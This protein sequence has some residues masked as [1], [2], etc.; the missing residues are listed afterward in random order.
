MH[1]KHKKE[2]K[3][4]QYTSRQQ[5][6][7]RRKKSLTIQNQINGYGGNNEKRRQTGMGVKRNDSDVYTSGQDVN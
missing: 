2:E 4:S 7:C 1:K 6:M 5:F 3:H